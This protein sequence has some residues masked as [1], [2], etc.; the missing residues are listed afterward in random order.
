MTKEE[1]FK[2]AREF[3]EQA[4]SLSEKKGND[5]NGVN[6]D[7]FSNFKAVEK[8][9]IC[10]VEQ[11][12]LA[13]MSDKFQRLIG[14]VNGNKLQV[15]DESVQDTLQDLMNYCILFAGYLKSQTVKPIIID[16]GKVGK[17]CFQCKSYTYGTTD[18]RCF[19]CTTYSNF[20][21]K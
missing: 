20:T 1:Y 11:G 10:S 17:T 13:R 5:Y 8:S 12:F 6:T 21:A 16:I 2:F 9:G 14:A 18:E 15:N 7:P 19:G 3:A 4:I